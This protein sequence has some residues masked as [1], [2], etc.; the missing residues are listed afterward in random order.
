MCR[1]ASIQEVKFAGGLFL[2]IMKYVSKLK[3]VKAQVARV[4]LCANP[5]QENFFP[6]NRSIKLVVVGETLLMSPRAA[7]GTRVVPLYMDGND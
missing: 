4:G 5:M 2:A 6:C 7:D 1:A 3:L